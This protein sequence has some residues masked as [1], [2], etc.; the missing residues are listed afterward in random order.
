[1]QIVSFGDILPEMSGLF[2]EKN[3]KN[4]TSFLPAELVLRV[5]KVIGCCKS[6]A[7]ICFEVCYRFTFIGSI[8]LLISIVSRKFVPDTS[9]LSAVLHRSGATLF[10]IQPV[11][12]RHFC[13]VVKYG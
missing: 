3:K 10:V 11:C 8:L 13:Q 12:F 4:I 5:V 6:T 2:S 1:M 9:L 7:S